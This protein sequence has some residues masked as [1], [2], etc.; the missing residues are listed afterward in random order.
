MKPTAF[1]HVASRCPRCRQILNGTVDPQARGAPRPGDL[2]VCAGCGTILRFGPKLALTGV[3]PEQLEQLPVE[4]ARELL[5]AKDR[6]AK[7]R[8]RRL[9]S[10]V[11]R[12][13]AS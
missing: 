3:T 4:T 8:T 13:A 9:L 10:S 6:F 5:A 7:S 11:P 12:R 1:R 2:T